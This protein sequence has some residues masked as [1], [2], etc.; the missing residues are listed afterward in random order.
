MGAELWIGSSY[1]QCAQS[2][3]R[4]H[5]LMPLSFSPALLAWPF[6]CISLSATDSSAQCHGDWGPARFLAKAFGAT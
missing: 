1:S 6:V 5:P 2:A 4:R 3:L